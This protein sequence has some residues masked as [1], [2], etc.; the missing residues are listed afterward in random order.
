M[1]TLLPLS[2]LALL[3]FVA[4]VR[5]EEAQCVSGQYVI[6]AS[7]F[8]AAQRRTADVVRAVTGGAVEITEKA[9]RA[10]FARIRSK[11][12]SIVNTLEGNRRGL[13]GALRR[14]R[15]A[16]L[17]AVR[18]ERVR[19]FN[20]RALS[21]S[22]SCNA[23]LSVSQSA[24]N[25]PHYPLL[26]GIEQ[27]NDID[28]DAA[29]AWTRSQG[30]AS[31]VVAVID[32][33]V[34]YQ[35]PD[36][37]PNMWR[38]EQEIPNNGI[39]DDGNGYID[40]VYGWNAIT[41]YGSAMDD[42]GHG[43]HVAGTIGAVGNNGIGITGVNWRVKIVPVK[44]IPSSG[45]GN[46]WHAILSIDYVTE[47]R[48]RGLP[49]VLSNNSWGGGGYVQPMYDA[50]VRARNSGILFVAAAGNDANNNDANPS[51]PANYNVENVISVAALDRDGNLASFS[52]YGAQTVDIAAPGVNIASTH[53]Q[54]GYVYMSGT[55]MAAP[56]VSGALALLKSAS[57]NLSPTELVDS[58]Y[59]HGDQYHTLMGV[60]RT[61]KMVNVGTMVMSA[62]FVPAPSDGATLPTPTPTVTPTP[63][64]T[65]T[66]TP[67]PTPTPTIAPGDWVVSGRVHLN[68]VGLPGAEVRITTD[69]DRII[70]RT[71]GP[72]GQ[73]QFEALRGP[74]QYRITAYASGHTFPTYERMLVGD[75]TIDFASDQR[76]FTVGG[77]VLTASG[78][79]IGGVLVDGGILGSTTTDSAGR[80]RF[81]AAYGVNY[82]F[83]VT[84]AGY[85]FELPELSGIV[86]GPLSRVFVASPN[87]P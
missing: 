81:N 9:R 46:L 77:L 14:D 36:L 31:V 37:A 49:I 32:T 34:D 35:H 15:R 61:A 11:R 70:S 75:V 85:Q 74:F 17:R 7:N 4:P 24:P 52:N 29:T 1:R 6:T 64:P 84:S 86:R 80:F 10:V 62:Q 16:A 73:Y 78:T 72:N 83:R 47:L 20:P 65:A 19:P 25:D 58:L 71:T 44:F 38:N 45:L 40:D 27:V 50:I 54:G 22:C 39:D 69:D 26:W 60:V 51:Y 28:I 8:G 42:H 82:T 87:S 63:S 67:T 56:H 41:G 12:T 57:W 79:P 59:A 53:L 43:T 13:C 2:C 3:I 18:N 66:A 21:R 23:I 30:S 76:Q 48:N 55:S 68:G 5:A 33:G